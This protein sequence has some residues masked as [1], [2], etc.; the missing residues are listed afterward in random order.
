MPTALFIPILLRLAGPIAFVSAAI[1]AGVLNRSFV[2]IFVL[3]AVAT[4]TTIVIRKISPSPA[5]DLKAVFSPDAAVAPPSIFR[6]AGRRFAIGLIGYAL[7]FG[8]S[9]LIAALFKTTEFEPQLRSGDLW[10][11]TIPTVI[12]IVG[13]F[14]SARLGM[15]QM[16]G[17]MDQM[18]GMFSQM[19]TPQGRPDEDRDAFTFEGE[20]I[21]PDKP[22]S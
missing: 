19:Q 9:A 7:V 1:V 14:V 12:A 4:A 18:Q 13:A 10:F 20:I 17:M 11:L 21:D 8:L 16:A 2:L 3:A 22:D 15:S 5:M 6:G